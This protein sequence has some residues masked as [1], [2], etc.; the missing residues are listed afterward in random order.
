MADTKKKKRI[1]ISACEPSADVHCARLIASLNELAATTEGW[2]EGIEWVGV[3]GDRMAKA[4]C[5]LMENTADRAAMLHHAFGQVGFYYRVLKRIGAYFEKNKVD[6][7]IV[8]DSPAFNFHV[9]R[10]A[11]RNGTKVLFYVAPQLWAWAAWRIW[12]LRMW[13]D[14]LACILPF[15]EEWFRS[16]GVEAVFV[17][18][19]LLDELDE[20]MWEKRREYADFDPW[21]AKI[22]LFPGSRSAEV[23]KLWPAMQKIAMNMQASWPRITFVV[24]A[25]NQERLQS[26]MDKEL[27]GFNCKYTISSVVDT[28]ASVDMAMV[29]SGS[30]TLEVAAA[31][32]P[33]VVMYQSSRLLWHLVGRW[34]VRTRFLSLVNILAGR[35]VIP[36]FMPYFS[37]LK[38]I[39]KTCNSL[40]SS[41]LRLMK[42]SSELVDVVKPLAKGYASEK[43]AHLAMEM[44]SEP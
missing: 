33:M 30:A 39:Q 16:R 17:G 37:S 31:G 36:E 24:G 18:N 1:F 26:L 14:K 6:L 2:E 29:A 7:V 35:E 8:C 12:K 42:I 3:G 13:C 40:L 43:V 22:A 19:P 11:K 20:S 5:E 4:G 10:L 27:R 28:A 41:K 9:A 44:L 38:P 15:E 21:Q 34:L 25:P 32:C 23:Q